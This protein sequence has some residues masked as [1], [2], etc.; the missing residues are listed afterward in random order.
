MTSVYVDGDH[1]PVKEEVAEICK[2]FGITCFFVASFSHYSHHS[3]VEDK[4]IYL[5]QGKDA[6]DFYIVGKIKRDDI[7][8]TSD[9]GLASLVLEKGAQAINN[10]GVVYTKET[11]DELLFTRYMNQKIRDAG[12]RHKKIPKYTFDDRKNFSINFTNLL[13]KFKGIIPFT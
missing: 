12:G 5:E 8:V 10:I 13:S 1:C 6:V 9:I 3:Q 7:V 11:I 4:W 2:A